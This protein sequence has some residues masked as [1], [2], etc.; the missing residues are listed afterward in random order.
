VWPK[1]RSQCPV[2]S[3]LDVIGDKWTLIVVRTIFAGRHRYTEL[4][5][6]PEGISTNIL[7]DR[8]ERLERYGLVTK[9]PYQR[10]PT[11]YQYRLTKR[12]A[13]LL[14]V[15]QELAVW[16]AHHIPDRWSSPRWFNEGKPAQFYP[17]ETV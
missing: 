11:R 8:L 10:N 9:N 5:E 14:P 1:F 3:A 13:D 17:K 4:A 15:L 7:A 6:I 2:A 12:G 16:A